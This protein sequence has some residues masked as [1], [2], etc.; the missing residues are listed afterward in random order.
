MSHDI[1]KLEAKVK[2]F[3]E[4]LSK[5]VALSEVLVPIMHRPGW[6]TLPESQ[7]V[8]LT[9]DNLSYQMDGALLTQQRLV[10]TAK[11]IGKPQPSPWKN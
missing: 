9:L 11:L 8:E 3:D 6:T 5:L 7:L 10:E 2:Q 1:N 4:K